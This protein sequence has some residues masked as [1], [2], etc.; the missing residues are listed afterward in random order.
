MALVNDKIQRALL[1]YRLQMQLLTNVFMYVMNAQEVL[2]L[3]LS[4]GTVLYVLLVK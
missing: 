2:N 3:Q 4:G 1:Y